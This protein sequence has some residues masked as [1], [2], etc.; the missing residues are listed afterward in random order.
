MF[1]I[2][3]C[4]EIY[5]NTR[6][7]F[8]FKFVVAFTGK[9]Q[10][11]WK[12][13][14]KLQIEQ[15]TFDFYI[16]IYWCKYRRGGAAWGSYWYSSQS[17]FTWW[18]LFQISNVN[19]INLTMVQPVLHLTKTVSKQYCTFINNTSWSITHIQLPPNNY[20]ISRKVLTN[21]KRT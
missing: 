8:R 7:P 10:Y 13:L 14:R 18:H 21:L 17:V 12:Y 16:N 2:L 11:A 9:Q 1:T 6:N 15:R 19:S 5:E 4:N 20:R 3:I